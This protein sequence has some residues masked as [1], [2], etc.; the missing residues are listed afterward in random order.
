MFTCPVSTLKVH[1]SG[2]TGTQYAP[3]KV[4]GIWQIKNSNGNTL[5]GY[6]GKVF[7]FE[8]EQ[9]AKNWLCTN[10]SRYKNKTTPTNVDYLLQLG[11]IY[12]ETGIEAV[13]EDIK[14]IYD[15]SKGLWSIVECAGDTQYI[16]VEASIDYD[17]GN[18]NGLIV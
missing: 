16:T 14:N 9:N 12:V 8:F 11:Q 7:E 6:R 15:Y 4:D 1:S 3:I 13:R 5:I 10:L 17:G 2:M 18:A